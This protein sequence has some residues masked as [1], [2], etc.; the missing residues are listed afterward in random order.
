MGDANVPAA[1]ELAHR[2][3]GETASLNTARLDVDRWLQESAGGQ[4]TRDAVALVVSELATNAVQAAPGHDFE[5]RASLGTDHVLVGVTN[6]FTGEEPP[7]RSQWGPDD[8]LAARGRGLAIV[9]AVAD[10]VEVDRDDDGAV[11]VSAA[12][13]LK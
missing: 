7:P 4:A 5:V 6:A 9:A 12:V 3:A 2:Y 1:T 11:T 13:P 8:V 10:S